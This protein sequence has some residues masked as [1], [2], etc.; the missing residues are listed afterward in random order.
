MEAAE[1]RPN[2][3]YTSGHGR[4]RVQSQP[5][6]LPLLQRGPHGPSEKAPLK[7]FACLWTNK[8]ARFL[9]RSARASMKFRAVAAHHSL[10]QRAAKFLALFNSKTSSKAASKNALRICA[11]W[12]SA[13]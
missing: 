10:W 4:L 12:A 7:P 6:S 9:K 3:R 1:V 13:P 5:S 8:A 2:S 11:K